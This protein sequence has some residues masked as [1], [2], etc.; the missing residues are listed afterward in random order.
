M[1]KRLPYPLLLCLFLCTCVRAQSSEG[2]DFWFTFLQHRDPDNSLVALIS[3]RE[4]TSGTLTIP[5][6][7]WQRAFTVGANEVAQIE[8]PR[9]AET[10]GSEVVRNTGVRLVSDR[11]V[12]LYIHQFFRS[13]S[14][15]SLVLPTAVLGTEYRVMAYTGRSTSQQEYPSAF[16]VVATEDDTEVNI[17]DLRAA[18]EGFRQ[19]GE[20]ITVRLNQGQTYQVRSSLGLDDLTGTLVTATAPVAV[21]SGASWSGIP[22]DCGLYDNLL[23]ISYPISQW[24]LEYVG[25]PTRNNTGNIY[26]VMAAEDNTTILVEGAANLTRTLSAG[27]FEDF[28]AADAVRI[29]GDKPVL[30]AEYLLGSNCAGHPTPELGDPSFFLLNEVS[31]TVD[32]VTV[33]NSRFENIEENYLNILFRSGDEVS[34]LLDGA[35]VN[36]PLEV[37]PGGEYSY[38]RVAV[39]AGSHTVTSGGCGVIVTVYGYGERESYAYGGGAAFRNIN[40]NPIVA[41]GCLNE[42]ILFSTGLDTLRFQHEWTLEDGS[43][44]REERF[45]RRYDQLGEFPIQLIITDECLNQRDTSQRNIR[46]TLRQAAMVPADARACVGDS[47][48]LQAVDLPEATYRWT[49][50]SGFDENTQAITVGPL[51]RDQDGLYTVVGDISGCKTE[52]ASVRIT[53][54]TLPVITFRADT[55][56]CRRDTDRP[57]LDAGDFDRYRWSDGQIAN[58]ITVTDEGTFSVTV[59]DENGCQTSDSLRV[60]EFCPTRAYLPNVFSPNGD[61]VNDSFGVF[62]V[63]FDSFSLRI[64]NRW[65]GLVFESSEAQPTWNGRIGEQEAPP[66]AY[67]YQLLLEGTD[68]LGQPLRQ[69]RRGT[70]MLVR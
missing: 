29:R 45:R 70:V 64:F 17:R 62:A 25:I 52:P 4:A 31:Q 40:V 11:P 35:P 12:S 19:A 55:V 15:A 53:V 2:R 58:P 54:D 66:G 50:P 20:D 38:Y 21:F 9:A 48:T 23:E 28:S 67:L 65:G 14:E 61:G 44:V 51:T 68:I 18:T 57:L 47:V 39:A 56:F 1:T 60:V 59:T 42:E 63:D 10:L 3:A 24:G 33:F 5:G 8:L 7:G 37:A 13:R 16:V 43:I 27:E 34:I 41:G 32:T 30:V 46:I 69:N 49:G 22:F 36:A 6:S 26:R